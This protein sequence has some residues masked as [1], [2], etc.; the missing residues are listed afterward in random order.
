ME[1]SMDGNYPLM[2]SEDTPPPPPP[3]PPIR[4]SSRIGGLASYVLKPFPIVFL[5]T[6]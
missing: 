6:D 1:I 2:I 5:T 4:R 3:P